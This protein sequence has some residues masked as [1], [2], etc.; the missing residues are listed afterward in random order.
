LIEGN[1]NQ[2]PTERK[3]DIDKM[4]GKKALMETEMAMHTNQETL[5]QMLGLQIPSSCSRV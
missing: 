3:L 4:G 5:N 2:N 1:N